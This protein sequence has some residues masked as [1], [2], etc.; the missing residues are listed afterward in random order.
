ME[1]SKVNLAEKIG[2][3]YHDFGVLLLNDNSGDVISFIEREQ[4][5]CACS[6][7][8]EVFK[9]WLKGTGRQPVAWDTLVA[10][11]N[12]I[13]MNKLANDI[14]YMTCNYWSS[15]PTQIRD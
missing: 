15:S 6:I 8:R 14:D 4:R 2:V 12:D 9:M 11:L 1:D 13:G 10:V 7:N 3:K 5:G